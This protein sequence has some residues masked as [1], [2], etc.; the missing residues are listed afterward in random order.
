MHRRSL[1][2]IRV[3]SPGISVAVPFQHLDEKIVQRSLTFAIL[4]ASYHLKAPMRAKRTQSAL[5]PMQG[6]SFWG[7]ETGRDQSI[8]NPLQW[9][10]ERSAGK[11]ATAPAAEAWQTAAPPEKEEEPEIHP[12]PPWHVGKAENSYCSLA[13]HVRQNQSRGQMQPI[14][15][16]MEHSNIQG[17]CR[18][19]FKALQITPAQLSLLFPPVQEQILCFLP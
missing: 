6:S 2:A 13:P 19:P 14:D 5:A 8:T 18:Q 11:A 1:A 15:H 16:H 3:M 10:D 4:Q 9:K 7:K 12:A 17:R